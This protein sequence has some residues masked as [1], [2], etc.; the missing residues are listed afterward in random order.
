[1]YAAE[2]EQVVPV[3]GNTVVSEKHVDESFAGGT[4]GN[5]RGRVVHE[6]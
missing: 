6:G 5:C 4:S 2:W 1:M 3:F